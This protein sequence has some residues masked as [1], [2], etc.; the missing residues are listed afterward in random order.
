MTTASHHR[1]G[2]TERRP[3][4]RIIESIRASFKNGTQARTALDVNDLIVETLAFARADLQQHQIT[5]HSEQNRELPQIKGDRVQLQRVLLNLITN[6]IES[7]S[8]VSD[9]GHGSFDLPFDHRSP[10]RSSLG[11]PRQPSGSAFRFTLPADPVEEFSIAMTLS[12]G[13]GRE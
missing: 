10:W 7:M 12:C 8:V 6:A 5:V 2:K 4:G 3:P 9:H 11:D 1:R 13:A